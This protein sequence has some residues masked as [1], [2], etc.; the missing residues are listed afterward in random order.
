MKMLRGRVALLSIE[1]A[2]GPGSFG[3]LL[4]CTLCASPTCGSRCTSYLGPG[5]PVRVSL[6]N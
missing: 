5:I 2:L 3:D 4:N 6:K 1:L